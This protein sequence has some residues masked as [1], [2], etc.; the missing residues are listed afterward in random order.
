MSANPVTRLNPQQQHAVHSISGP[1]LVLAGAGSGKT[2]V[3]TNKIVYLIRECGY[4]AQQVVALTF[5]NKA[6]REMK[7]R[8]G[9]MLRPNERK[10][11]WVSTFHTLGLRILKEDGHYIGLT[12]D[13]SIFDAKD[14]LEILK[15]IVKSGDDKALKAL[16]SSISNLKNDI[17]NKGEYD[18]AVHIATATYNT[19]LLALNA[20]DFDDLIVHCLT[21]LHDYP[22]VLKKWQQRIRY[23]LLDEY[24]D[25]NQSQYQLVK[26]L[27]N[28]SAHFTAVGDDDQSIYSWR[29]AEAENLKLLS[30]DFPNLQ[31]IKLEQ[32]YRCDRR[33][34]DAANAL[35]AHN[36]HLFNK[37]LWSHIDNG[38]SIRV[39]AY[40]T[41][42]EEAL[43][44]ISDIVMHHSRFGT[45][46][47]DYAIL[48]RGN[49]QSRLLEKELRQQRL[50]YVINGST[51]FFEHTEVR[52]LLAYMRVI[53]NP[54][55][56][57]AFVRIVN[58]PKR[59]IGTTTLQK[60]SE[61]ARSRHIGLLPAC[62]EAGLQ[63]VMPAAAQKRLYEFAK[64]LMDL[65][66]KAERGESPLQLFDWVLGDSE[67]EN[68]VYSQYSTAKA[69]K[70]LALIEELR[71]WLA[72]L[73]DNDDLN[74]LSEIIQR[75]LL[76]DM[77]ENKAE[78]ENRLEAISLMTLHAAKGLEFPFV[79]IVGLEEGL[80]P[81]ANS[82]ANEAGIEEERRLLYVGMTRAKRKLSMS[83]AKNRKTGGNMTPV[84]PSRF[85]DELP[86]DNIDWRGINEVEL[87]PEQE[88]SRRDNIMAD[89]LSILGEE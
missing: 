59:E 8:A 36:P 62:L 80:L 68:Y 44:V 29:G 1:V 82:S 63:Q 11:L 42:A 81:H 60:L 55:D 32:N 49:F 78:D 20:V 51:S 18:Q 65:H 40:K 58:T 88:Q 35:I 47:S 10:G 48:Y 43:S 3:I 64:W 45:R 76:L 74:G 67:Y 28:E 9:K 23:L 53:A 77:L 89:L 50:P 85:L 75:M 72:R 41:D 38:E 84:E 19:H 6:A 46:L 37:R 17:L 24:Q 27:T 73:N 83:L 13:F 2:R 52:D 30:E 87:S 31:V 12:R 66:E 22:Q 4:K 70:R 71:D 7:E 57:R 79:F 5:T 56:Q 25:T 14:C 21:L 16:Q 61:Y 26:L 33:I 39:S 69:E 34:L 86:H 54:D 15:E